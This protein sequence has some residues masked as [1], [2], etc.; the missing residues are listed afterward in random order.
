[1][2]SANVL[3]PA[4]RPGRGLFFLGLLCPLVGL[5][6]YMA[7]VS[8]QRLFTPWYLPAL[9]FLGLVLVALSLR[10]KRSL[11]RWIGFVLI[12]LLTA[13]TCAFL[14]LT[15][16][17]AYAGLL[18]VGEPYPAFETARADGTPFTQTDLSGSQNTV[19]VFFRGRW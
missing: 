6:A 8:A 9:S 15:R 16:L 14:L 18:Q 13:A 7:Q 12:A 17:P 19:L 1:M 2:S 10:E 3:V 11:T 5:G 4:A